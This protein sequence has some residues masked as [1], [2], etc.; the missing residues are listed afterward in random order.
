MSVVVGASGADR[1][2]AGVLV[3]LALVAGLPTRVFHQSPA[4]QM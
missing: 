4:I 2:P 3:L 1:H